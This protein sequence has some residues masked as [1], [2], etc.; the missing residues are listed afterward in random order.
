M[1]VP[2]GLV[3]SLQLVTTWLHIGKR[4]YVARAG[5]GD[6]KKSAVGSDAHAR[7]A[8]PTSTVAP[9]GSGRPT[10]PPKNRSQCRQTGWQ[11]T[12]TLPSG[13]TAT[14]GARTARRQRS[15]HRKGEPA[16]SVR[17]ASLNRE[18]RNRAGGR[19]DLQ[20]LVGDKKEVCGRVDGHAQGRHS[21]G[22][23]DARRQSTVGFH[24]CRSKCCCVALLAIN[25]A[26]PDG[27]QKHRRRRAAG[28]HPVTIAV[29]SP[30]DRS[31][32]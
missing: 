11:H 5:I 13:V 4:R 26:F 19:I 27:R 16:T 1:S 25:S 15:G 29:S 18:Y 2:S 23:A 7:G 21:R 12:G 14:P 8:V 17:L 20:S 28:G 3:G 24:A 30:V 22:V 10:H 6:I 32:V 31:M 9:S